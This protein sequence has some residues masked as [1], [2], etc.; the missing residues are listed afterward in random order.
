MKCL[1]DVFKKLNKE[2]KEIKFKNNNIYLYN[3]NLTANIQNFL[4]LDKL[5]AYNMLYEE[6]KNILT[7][8]NFIS[9]L[10]YMLLD[11]LKKE[12]YCFIMKEIDSNKDET[13][14]ELDEIKYYHQ[15]NELDKKYFIGKIYQGEIKGYIPTLILK[16]DS[17]MKKYFI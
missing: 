3:L 5:N 15:V 8:N 17:K 11:N 2:V 6:L 9:P 1:K 13:H 7:K 10:K 4:L 14:M 16:N 12:G